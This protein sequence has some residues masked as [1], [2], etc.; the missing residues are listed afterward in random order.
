MPFVATR[1]PS[2]SKLREGG[3]GSQTLGRSFGSNRF[4]KLLRGSRLG[5][6]L[7]NALLPIYRHSTALPILRQQLHPCEPR[8]H[9]PALTSEALL[10]SL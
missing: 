5:T 4:V 8:K 7:L 10:P 2:I 3:H 9:V 6:M 1:A